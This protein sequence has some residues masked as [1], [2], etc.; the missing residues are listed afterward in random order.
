VVRK[1]IADGIENARGL[2]LPGEDVWV[3]GEKRRGG[4]VKYYVTNHPVNTPVTRI[5]RDL[6]ARWAC[7]TLHAQSKEELGLD[8]FE[9]RSWRGLSHHVL[10]VLL[11]MLFLQVVRAQSFGGEQHVTLPR[12]RREA[13][14][15]LE[16]VRLGRCPHC[17][18]QI[19]GV[20]T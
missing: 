10:L 6:R 11:A 7:E 15:T 4:E 3:V 12:A 5:V 2:H 1:R 20:P 17:G 19:R 18:E 14:R 13:S 8:H 9:G 16:R